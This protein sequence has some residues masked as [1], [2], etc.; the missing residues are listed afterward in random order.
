MTGIGDLQLFTFRRLVTARGVLKFYEEVRW[1]LGTRG[2]LILIA[3][4]RSIA[5]AASSMESLPQVAVKRPVDAMDLRY[6]PG[7][8]ARGYSCVT[9]THILPPLRRPECPQRSCRMAR[10]MQGPRSRRREHD[11]RS[12]EIGNELPQKRSPRRPSASFVDSVDEPAEPSSQRANR[13]GESASE[14]DALGTARESSAW[15]WWRSGQSASAGIGIVMRVRS[16]IKSE[17]KRRHGPGA[18]SPRRVGDDIRIDLEARGHPLA[19]ASVAIPPGAPPAD[20]I[21]IR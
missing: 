12:E 7:W 16:P 4:K 8:Q 3:L 1:G 2:V 10:G 14:R 11:F 6:R 9:C 18:M 21:A 5:T 19:N 20:N 13:S 17:G 15:W